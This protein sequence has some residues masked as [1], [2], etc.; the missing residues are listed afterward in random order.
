MALSEPAL[1]V[2]DSGGYRG[3]LRIP[4]RLHKVTLIILTIRNP[5]VLASGF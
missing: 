1:C 5:G 4:D 2:V 3:R